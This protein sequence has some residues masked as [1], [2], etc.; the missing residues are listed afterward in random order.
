MNESERRILDLLEKFKNSTASAEEM[1]ELERWYNSFDG[2]PKLTTHY[3]KDKLSSTR[4]EIFHNIRRNLPVDLTKKKRSTHLKLGFFVFAS[5][6]VLVVGFFTWKLTAENEDKT[7]VMPGTDV[8]VLT[9]E[10]GEKIDLSRARN[11]II[12]SNPAIEIRKVAN[13][14]ILYRSTRKDQVNPAINTLSTPA[15]GQFEVIL[16]DGTHVWLNAVSSL[17]YATKFSGKIRP[18]ELKGEGYFEVAKDKQHPFIVNTGKETIKVLGTHFNINAYADEKT[19]RTTLLEGSVQINAVKNSN[20]QVIIKPGQQA[21]I[22]ED[23]IT[24]KQV[25]VAAAAAWKNGLFAFEHAELHELMRQ[26]SRW[27]NIDVV[28]RGNFQ[29]RAFSGEIDRTYTLREVLKV[30]ELGKINFKIETSSDPNHRNKLILT[31]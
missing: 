18:V 19:Q 16:E 17:T 6:A 5:L 13:N 27:Y 7:D 2:D 1:A 31:P 21:E 8:A 22:V 10:N 4:N 29:P 28:Y 14:K 11:G 15:G 20:Q 30:L 25:D 12:Y 26:L 24:V 3:S 23:K 9:L